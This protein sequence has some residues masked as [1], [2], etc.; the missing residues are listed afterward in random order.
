MIGAC[1]YLSCHGALVRAAEEAIT[2]RQ[3]EV[4]GSPQEDRSVIRMK[5]MDIPERAGVTI[6]MEHPE[7]ATLKEW[8]EILPVVLPVRTRMPRRATRCGTTELVRC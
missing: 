7:R 4:A 3:A 8:V 6:M 2:Q 5:G 1:L